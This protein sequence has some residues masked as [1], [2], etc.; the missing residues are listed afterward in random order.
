MPIKCIDAD[1]DMGEAALCL[2]GELG[3]KC[4]LKDIERLDAAMRQQPELYKEL[5]FYL[6][7]SLIT[8]HLTEGKNES[9]RSAIE[10]LLSPFY[11]QPTTN[12]EIYFDVLEK[13]LCFDQPLLAV[14]LCKGTFDAI[15]KSEEFFI[16]PK[17]TLS[18][19]IFFDELQKIYMLSKQGMTPDWVLFKK[20]MELIDLEFSQE[21]LAAIEKVM[22]KHADPNLMVSASEK[23]SQI[24]L[25]QLQ[26]LFC[27]YMHDFD[28]TS[29]V[30]SK[31][32]AAIIFNFLSS[33]PGR[34][35]CAFKVFFDIKADFILSYFQ[36][37]QYS[38]WIDSTHTQF[39][40]LASLPL[41][42]IF[43]RHN[44]ILSKEK[45]DAAMKG[46]AAPSTDLEDKFYERMSS[47]PATRKL[48]ALENALK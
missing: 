23:V 11:E 14:E 38:N 19:V 31:H 47:H 48:E 35:R 1:M 22:L 8:L 6:S 42:Y 26:L 7:Q 12:G 30:T 27:C 3:E 16:N 15:A 41:F 28:G 33:I 25:L 40:L 36:K 46:F 32:I 45:V 39:T 18:D 29:F 43:L 34:E 24:A 21:Y 17:N 5:R 37:L 20:K 9:Q 13:L 44:G 2:L 4:A 10:P